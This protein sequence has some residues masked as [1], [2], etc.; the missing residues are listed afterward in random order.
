MSN[1][2]HIHEVLFLFQEKGSY[3][4]EEALFADIKERHGKDVA[5]TSCSNQPFGL[6]AVVDFL[7]QREKIV[8]NADGSLSLHPNMTMCNGHEDSESHH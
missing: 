4:N 6:D 8:Q 7:L 2:K 1:I 3:A 5:F